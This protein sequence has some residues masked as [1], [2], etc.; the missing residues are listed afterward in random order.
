M[1]RFGIR[2]EA[3]GSGGP[4]PSKK[5]GLGIVVAQDVRRW[6]RGQWRRMRAIGVRVARGLPAQVRPLGRPGIRLAVVVSQYIRSGVTL[7]RG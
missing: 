2:A 6:G 3:R 4:L 7:L 1:Q 5:T